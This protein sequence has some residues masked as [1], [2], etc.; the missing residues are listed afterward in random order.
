MTAISW[1]RQAS[2]GDARTGVMSTPH[3]DVVTPNFMAVGTRATVKTIDTE[4]L[5]RLGSDIVLAN[6]YHLMLRP[7]ERVVSDLGELHG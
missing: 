2:N 3:G 1:R 7:G 4:D 5:E 6:T